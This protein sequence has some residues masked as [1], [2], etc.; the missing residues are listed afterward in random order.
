M[1]YHGARRW[2]RLLAFLGREDRLQRPEEKSKFVT[3]SPIV[4]LSCQ[5]PT[6]DV[7]TTK[8]KDVCDSDFG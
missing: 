7:L 4:D 6:E 5:L 1:V 8:R 2:M 3:N